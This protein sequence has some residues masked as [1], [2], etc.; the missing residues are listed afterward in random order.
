MKRRYTQAQLN[1]ISGCYAQKRHKLRV[2]TIDRAQPSSCVLSLLFL[3]SQGALR[4]CGL[5][6]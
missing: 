2:I 5:A 3:S 6:Y 4:A 1:A